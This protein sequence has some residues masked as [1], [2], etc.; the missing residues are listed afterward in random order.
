[1]S[2]FCSPYILGEDAVQFF[3]DIQEAKHQIGG[4][5]LLRSHVLFLAEEVMYL[6]YGIRLFD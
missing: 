1:M 5:G 3:I 2:L 4:G 6:I